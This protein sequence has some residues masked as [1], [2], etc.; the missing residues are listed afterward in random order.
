[1]ESRTYSVIRGGKFEPF[2]VITR[3]VY[4]RTL[5]LKYYIT[6]WGGSASPIKDT[7]RFCKNLGSSIKFVKENCEQRGGL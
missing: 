4:A 2:L 6:G 5:Y 3:M 1:M 7:D